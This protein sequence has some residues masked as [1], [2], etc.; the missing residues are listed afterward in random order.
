VHVPYVQ[1]F[2]AIL[3]DPTDKSEVRLIYANQTEDDILLRA[4]LDELAAAHKNFYVWYVGEL[5]PLF[6]DI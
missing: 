2:K 4:E 1:V 3:R 5:P 6:H